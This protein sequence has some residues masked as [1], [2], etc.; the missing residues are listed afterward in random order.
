MIDF[1]SL[2]KRFRDKIQFSSSGC[3]LWQAYTN[4]HGYGVSRFGQ[5]M[6]CAHRAIWQLLVGEIPRTKHLDHKCRV[7]NCVNPS[8]LE[9]VTP[10]ENNFRIKKWNL[11][12]K[13]HCKRGHV[14]AE[15]NIYYLGNRKNCRGCDHMWNRRA[16]EKKRGSL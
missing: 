13:T 5:S 10:A 14:Y 12:N 1:C 7:R 15:G 11:E 4:K 9:I 8:H 6:I 3:W 2:P 16:R